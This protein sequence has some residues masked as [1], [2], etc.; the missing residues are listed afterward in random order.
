MRCRS[1]FNT[2]YRIYSNRDRPQ[3]EAYSN[4]SRNVRAS[5]SSLNHPIFK[6][7]SKLGCLDQNWLIAK[8]VFALAPLYRVAHKY[9]N[10]GHCIYTN[11]DMP[12]KFFMAF[13]IQKMNISWK[14]EGYRC[15][16][17]KNIKPL[18]SWFYYR[19]LGAC[20][21]YLDVTKAKGH[22]ITMIKATK[23]IFMCGKN[24]DIREHFL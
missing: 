6:N 2:T 4:T 5:P 13:S 22:K 1:S 23:K 9:L 7:C 14:F 10:P 21:W 3:I 20:I 16:I 18:F 11:W 12:I 8:N 19:F 17:K 15:N 24:C